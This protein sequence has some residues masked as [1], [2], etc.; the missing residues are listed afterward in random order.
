[1]KNIIITALLGATVSLSAQTEFL[2]GWDFDGIGA[3]DTSD[4]ANWGE[5]AGSATLS[6]THS[7]SNPPVV[8]TAEFG[9]S[10]AFNDT[11]AN[12]SFAGVFAGDV[13][14]QNG[15]AKFSDGPV[16]AAE[17]GF[18]S[19]SAT[20]TMTFSFD[21]SGFNSLELRFG[22]DAGS[23]FSL[24]TVDL[25]A[26]DGNTLAEYTFTTANGSSYDNFMI[27]GT[28]V[29]EPSAFAAIFGVVA[30]AFAGVRRRRK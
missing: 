7:P 28:A 18:N 30:L 21:A 6:W 10:N 24:Q 11:V 14:P 16:A 1:M 2:A 19:L 15:F 8:F 25:G 5:Q 26:F 3:A 27:T 4:I 20:D 9:L 12:D 17:A 13:D 22:L 29:P 23:G